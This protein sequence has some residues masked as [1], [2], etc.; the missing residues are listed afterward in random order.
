MRLFLAINLDPGVRRAIVEAMTPLKDAAP[1]LS[2]SDESRVHLTLKFF[3]DQAED[4][5]SRLGTAV[6]A[7]AARHRPFPL[8]VTG[9]GE[10]G[11]DIQEQVARPGGQPGSQLV[12]VHRRDRSRSIT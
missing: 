7:V 12:I 3:G 9:V 8:R 5:V 11:T 6:E 4:V 1:S 2:W 10:F